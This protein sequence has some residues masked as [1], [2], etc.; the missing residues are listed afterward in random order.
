MELLLG[1]VV[2]AFVGWTIP[3]PAWAK[4]LFD[5]FVAAITSK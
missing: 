5:K 2:G 4:A 1:F 3:Q